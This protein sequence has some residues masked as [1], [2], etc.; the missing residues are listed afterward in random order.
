[1]PIIIEEPKAAEEGTIIIVVSFF[2]EESVAV[3]PTSILWH[4]TDVNGNIA[5][6]LE[7]QTET[8]AETVEIVLKGDDLALGG[9]LVGF[10]RV[11]TVEALYNST[12]GNDLPLKEQAE[13][14]I[15]NFV[16]VV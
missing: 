8:P 14:E 16:K 7:D 6:S 9:N 12:L 1:M 4:L 15:E 2:D 10:V 5:N 3:T 11:F 13:F